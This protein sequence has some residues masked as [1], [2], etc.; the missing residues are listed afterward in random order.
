MSW[1][2]RLLCWLGLHHWTVSDGKLIADDLV[3]RIKRGHRCCL[4][5]GKVTGPLFRYP[6]AY[7]YTCYGCGG[8][9]SEENVRAGTDCG[10]CQEQGS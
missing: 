3:G 9:L 8:P 4:R 1:K 6:P 7:K 2:Y 5:C 10:F